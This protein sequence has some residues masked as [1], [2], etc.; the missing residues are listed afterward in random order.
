[1]TTFKNKGNAV[2][3][4]YLFHIYFHIYFRVVKNKC[5]F[6]KDGPKYYIHISFP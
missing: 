1:M 4:L 5:T 2:M 3:L 6:V